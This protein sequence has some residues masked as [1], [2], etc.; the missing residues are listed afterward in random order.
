[1]AVM[2]WRARAAACA[3]VAS[4]CLAC[5]LAPHGLPAQAL[6]RAEQVRVGSE[7]ERYL[8]ALSLL[9]RPA[10]AGKPTVRLPSWT[11]R[12]T[13]GAR[14]IAALADVSGPWALDVTPARAGARVTGGEVT[15]AINS[16]LPS[17]TVADGSAWSGKGANLSITGTAV[18]RRGRV[19]LRVSPVGWFA[20][21]ASFPLVP[22]TGVFPYS[23]PV[24]PEVIDIPQR[25]GDGSLG[26]VDPGESELEVRW[27]HVRLALT[28]AAAQ[29]GP[30]GDHSLLMQGNAG[31]IPRLELGV[32]HGLDTRLGSFA[33]HVAWGRNP[34]TAW[35]PDRRTGALYTSHLT[36]TWTPPVVDR[37]ELGFSRLTHRDWERITVR[38]LVVPFGS[39]YSA[40][41][42]SYDTEN[43]NQ[44]ASFFGRLRV[45]EAGMEFFGEYGKND[46]SIDWRD[47]LVEPD[48]NSAWLLGAQKSWRDGRE[49]LWSLSVTGVNGAISS[50]TRFRG[51]ALFYEHDVMTQGHTLR[52]QLLGTPL[53]QREGGYEVRLDRYDARGR[54]GLLLGTRALPNERAES[55]TPENLR[56][57]W[58][59]MVE[60]MRWTAGGSWR[61]RLGGVADVGYSPVDGD[62]FSINLGLS[63]A[64]GR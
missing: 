1:M 62:V 36:L 10:A 27:T 3:G 49:R 39:V 59:A 14:M 29:L 7:Q 56:Q 58:S 12:P 43:D 23:D 28:S 20:Q 13:E 2:R 37:L 54:L 60:M 15:L 44:L 25:F 21:N 22:T 9:E 42:G 17:T 31:G 8:R 45:P 38:E 32:P 35:A 16:G 24:G 4:A 55:P 53:L 18:A 19:R 30:A 11:I 33:A 50:V 40:I 51:Q 48:H 52:G 34:H 47:Q 61:A 64:R 6:V 26:R 5:S 46:R 41:G 63:Y 57:E